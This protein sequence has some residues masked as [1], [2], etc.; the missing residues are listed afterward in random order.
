MFYLD[1]KRAAR[2][3]QSLDVESTRLKS[4]MH[5]LYFWPLF[6][7]IEC[8]L[9]CSSSVSQQ[10]NMMAYS[11]VQHRGNRFDKTVLEVEWN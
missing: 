5:A 10:H 6:D 3:S 9:L 8:A 4:S 7:L 2:Q 11:H 1:A